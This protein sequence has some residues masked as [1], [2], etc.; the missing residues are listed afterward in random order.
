MLPSDCTS[1]KSLSSTSGNSLFFSSLYSG[2]QAVL[3]C[4]HK[5][6]SSSL[7]LCA[8]WMNFCDLWL[9]LLKYG[10][11]APALCR[12]L[13][14]SR[15]GRKCSTGLESTPLLRTALISSEESCPLPGIGFLSPWTQT[16][17]GCNQE[18]CWQAPSLLQSFTQSRLSRWPPSGCWAHWAE[19][20]WLC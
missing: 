10:L 8:T 4:M 12:W 16:F 17:L 2:I 6:V 14:W 15:S 1:W 7:I 3:I 13:A 20:L 9:Q 18:R 19:V 5:A 11:R